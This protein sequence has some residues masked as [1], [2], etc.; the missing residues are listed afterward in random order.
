MDQTLDEISLKE[1]IL[2]LKNWNRYILS[3]W[4]LLL[5]SCIIGGSIGIAYALYQKPIYTALTNY[6][7][8]DE[9]SGGGIG[10]ALGLASSLGLDLGISAGGAF[11]SANLMELMHSRSLIEKTLLSEVLWGGDKITL[12]DLY[13]EVTGLREKWSNKPEL[14]KLNFSLNKSRSNFSRIED[15]ILGTIYEC[16]DKEQLSITQK[17]KKVSIGTIEVKSVNEKFAK[18]FCETLV[19]EVS[20]FYIETKSRK[21]RNNVLILQKQADSVREELNNAISGVAAANDNTFNLNSALSVKRTDV[22]RRQ[23][24]VQA[25]TAIL[26]QLVANL[27]MANVSLLKETPLFQIIDKPIM[28]L[29]KEKVSKLKSLVIGGS[30]AGFLAILFLVLKR[31]GKSIMED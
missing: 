4:H 14:V 31:I 7:L 13:I 29:K 3:K 24:D 18:V 27:E 17:D 30:L 16:I 11:A 1:L 23:V 12:A 2:K 9:K 5:F 6:A 10:N 28:P 19:K 20:E 25:N 8:D 22:A 21:A 26:T 15:S